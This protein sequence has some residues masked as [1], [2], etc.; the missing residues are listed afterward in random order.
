MPEG[1][2]PQ[3]LERVFNLDFTA[4]RLA[5]YIEVNIVLFFR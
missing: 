3:T 1:I 5:D 4:R 2:N